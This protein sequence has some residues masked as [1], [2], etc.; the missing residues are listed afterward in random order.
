[1][2]HTF[3]EA[4]AKEGSRALPSPPGLPARSETTSLRG[5]CG[6]LWVAPGQFL[7]DSR[8]LLQRVKKDVDRGT[9]HSDMFLLQPVDGREGAYAGWRVGPGGQWSAGSCPKA[10]PALWLGDGEERVA[11]CPCTLGW[12]VGVSSPEQADQ[13]FCE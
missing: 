13:A 7:R 6:A 10:L 1:M 11:T 5:P 9:Q 2:V 4:A 12:G 3:F 8:F